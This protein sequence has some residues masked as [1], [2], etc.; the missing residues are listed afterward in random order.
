VIPLFLAMQMFSPVDPAVL[1]PI[2]E[3]AIAL[4]TKQFGKNS[5]EAAR[6]MIDYGR[7]LAK[8]RDILSAVDWIRKALAIDPNVEDRQM[9]ALLLEPVDAA[10]AWELDMQIAKSTKGETAAISFSRLGALA[11]EQGELAGAEIVY[12]RAVAESGSEEKR[13]VRMNTLA[14][15]LTKQPAK[16]AEAEA[17]FRGALAIQQRRLGMKH[18]EV[19]VTL[20]N[21]SRMLLEENRAAEAE[22]EARRALEIFEGSLGPEHLRSGQAARSLADVLM[23]RGQK[24]QARKLYER[25]LAVFEKQLGSE[26]SW[27]QA[28][29]AALRP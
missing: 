10:A 8:E 27:T 12:R 5:K 19:A 18:P 6:T 3:N 11:E 7:F 13:A 16:Q 14:L 26:H 4:R 25:A 1:R 20:N 23:A 17:L 28:A 2:Y 22:P 21:L 24:A 29:R 9:L 15:I